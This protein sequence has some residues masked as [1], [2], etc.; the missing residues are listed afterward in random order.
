MWLSLSYQLNQGPYNVSVSEGSLFK[1]GEMP[2]QPYFKGRASC[3]SDR[4]CDISFKCVSMSTYRDIYVNSFFPHTARL[5][6]SLPTKCSLTYDLKSLTSQVNWQ[7]SSI[8]FFF[9]LRFH[10]PEMVNI[11]FPILIY[12]AVVNINMN[13]FCISF[14]IT[15]MPHFCYCFFDTFLIIYF[16]LIFIFL[17]L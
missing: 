6:N 15:F 12:F 7:L 3:Y 9:N 5:R 1:L 11:S 13:R 2:S 16:I 14:L 4:L 8:F 10:R 17:C